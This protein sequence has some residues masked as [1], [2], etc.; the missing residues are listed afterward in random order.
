MTA[1]LVAASAAEQNNHLHIIRWKE[2]QGNPSA[3]PQRRQ[4]KKGTSLQTL[5]KNFLQRCIFMSVLIAS[6][7]SKIS[8]LKVVKKKKFFHLSS[9]YRSV[10]QSSGS[11]YQRCAATLWYALVP[12]LASSTQ[13]LQ[14]GPIITAISGGITSPR[15]KHRQESC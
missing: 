14:T 1:W 6:A 9:A 12:G 11:F 5:L 10:N 3:A 4:Q 15:I 2:F 8:L 7:I 13:R